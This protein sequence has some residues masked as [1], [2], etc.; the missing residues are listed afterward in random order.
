MWNGPQRGARAGRR[1]A[2]MFLDSPGV[3][4]VMSRPA[5]TPGRLYAMMSAEFQEAR[6]RHCIGC[7][8]PLLA[9]RERAGAS[10]PNWGL[11]TGGWRCA[12]CETAVARIFTKYAAIYD[13]KDHSAA[14]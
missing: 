2:H 3:L 6:P 8:M 5:L 11:E 7:I 10:Q 14:R 12:T 9:F 4:E 1:L 13:V